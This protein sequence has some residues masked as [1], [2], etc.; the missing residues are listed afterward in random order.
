MAC[1]IPAGKSQLNLHCLTCST[2]QMKVRFAS[3]AY[4]RQ[5][6]QHQIVTPGRALMCLLAQV[7][8]HAV[9]A[10]CEPDS[11]MCT[12]L[13]EVC[14]RKGDTARALAMY[15]RMRDAPAGSRLAPSV[16]AFTSAMRA[17]A[18][19]GAWE[20][21]LDI[22]NDMVAAGCQPTGMNALLPPS[23]HSYLNRHCDGAY[24]ILLGR[25]GMMPWIGYP[26][27]CKA[28]L[29]SLWSSFCD[30]TVPCCGVTGWIKEFLSGARRLQQALGR[31]VWKL[32]NSIPH[33]N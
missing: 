20:K 9:S 2:V 5:S 24:A 15:D 3:V 14:T 16:H 11:R 17:A 12:T 26:P 1:D 33:L 23:I 10:G 32:Q 25:S 6:A 19:G 31:L 13:L 28:F 27:G 8:D 30:G 22:W 21:A 29:C 18:D 4:E 7:W